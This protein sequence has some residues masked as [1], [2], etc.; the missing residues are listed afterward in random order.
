MEIKVTTILVSNNNIKVRVHFWGLT[1]LNFGS[2]CKHRETIFLKDLP[3][4]FTTSLSV[5]PVSRLGGSF[6]RVSIS[7]YT[8]TQIHKHTHTHTGDQ[9]PAFIGV[10][11][12]VHAGSIPK[13]TQSYLHWWI[14]VIGRSPRGQFDGR[15][16]KTPDVSFKIVA[17]DLWRWWNKINC[18]S[19]IG[20]TKRE[21]R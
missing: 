12:C 6:C 13:K 18:G 9:K 20:S 8:N 17:T 1:D 15:Y 3:Y 19:V 21:E 14:L 16:S 2:F 4:F 11:G 10:A 7:T 5:I